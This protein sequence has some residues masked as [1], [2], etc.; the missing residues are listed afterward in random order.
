MFQCVVTEELKLCD[1][2]S[3]EHCQIMH[4]YIQDLKDNPQPKINHDYPND[5][6]TMPKYI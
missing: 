4:D 6:D 1:Y 5:S 2:A 3:C